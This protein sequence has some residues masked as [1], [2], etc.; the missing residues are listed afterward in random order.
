MRYYIEA[1]TQKLP[2]NLSVRHTEKSDPR[3]RMEFAIRGDATINCVE[4]ICT[5]IPPRKG[6]GYCAGD[7][8]ERIRAV[9]NQ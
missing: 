8:A 1:T 4:T 6:A 7:Y 2:R 5:L 3:Q 9:A